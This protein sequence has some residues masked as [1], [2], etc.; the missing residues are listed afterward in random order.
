MHALDLLTIAAT[1]LQDERDTFEL[2][3]DDGAFL[4][5][6]FEPDTDTSIMDEQGAGVWCGRLEWAPRGERYHVGQRSTRRPYDFDGGA[7]IIHTNGHGGALWWDVPADL[8][9]DAVKDQRDS[10][11]RAIV[12]V[13]E[14]GYVGIVVEMCAGEDH[15][16]APIVRDAASLWGIEYDPDREYRAAVVRDLI[17]EL[18]TRTGG[19]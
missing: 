13:I 1:E 11:R 16:G 15:Y 9:G 7:E 5:V 6:R 17:H 3:A 2:G 19:E 4:R 12:N 10:C 8:R 14:N 18:V